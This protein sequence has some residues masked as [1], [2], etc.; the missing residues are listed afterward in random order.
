VVTLAEIARWFVYRI[1]SAYHRFWAIIT[2]RDKLLSGSERKF[3]AL[4]ESAPDPIVIIDWHGHIALVNA[5]FEAVFG[6]SRRE[7]LGN[8][9][10][11][12]IP[13]RLRDRHRQHMKRYMKA[14]RTRPMGAGQDLLGVR[15]DG[16]EFPIEISLSPLESAEGLLVSA[17]I[18]DVTERRL[19][20]ER[21][22]YLADHD[23]LT[24]L[25]NR[26]SFEENLARELA[27][28]D[29]YHR[30]G[31]MLLVDLDGLKDV[32]DTLGHA[33]GDELLR[34]IGEL[35]GSRTRDTDMVGRIGGDE[36]AVLLPGTTVAGAKA[37][38]ED[39]LQSIRDHG[40]VAGAQRLRATAC[41]GIAGFGGEKTSAEDVM[42]AADLAL[43]EAKNRGRNRVIVHEPVPGEA[44]LAGQRVAW[45]QR[46]RHGLDEDL[47]VPYL[48][49]IM[50]LSDGSVARY[51]LLA[52]MI[53]EKGQPV[54]PGA[55]LPTAERS[56]M[57]RELDRRMIAWAID[58]IARCEADSGACSYEVNLSARSLI[59]PELPGLI[60]ARID[61]AGIDP[62]NLVFEITETAAIANMDQART[63]ANQLRD[64]GCHFALDDFGAGFASFYYLKHVPLDALKI[65]G[66]FIANLHHNRTDQLLVKHMAEIAASLGLYTIAEFVEN[67]ETL[68]MLTEYGIDAAQGF[69]VG[70]PLPLPTLESKGSSASLQSV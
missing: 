9:V 6:F 60:A 7:V 27:I 58:L 4:I 44:A 70:H 30:E 65:D 39:L 37:L 43:Y 22:R 15:A 49:P 68:E 29:R 52:R 31:A 8:N 13:E 2:R 61:E 48:Q 20:E 1:S 16:T 51:E 19:D 41:A 47:F 40:M 18:R 35:I 34:N 12:L 14:P 53:D 57:I 33:H 67:Q 56:G 3:R 24:G 11:I 32:N 5:Q 36:F 42:V 10:S 54:M 23:A 26:R 28:T 59:D 66:D 25:A 17:V 38:A 64:L 69:H 63:F 50:S 21:L 46:I 45:A 62:A 55:F